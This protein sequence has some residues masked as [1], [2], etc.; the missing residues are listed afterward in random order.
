[1]PAYAIAFLAFKDAEAYQRYS[2][3]L[4]PLLQAHGGT[5]LAGDNHP[6]ALA[7]PPCDR[8]VLLQFAD[9]AAALKLFGSAEYAEIAQDRDKGAHV[10][11][12][13]VDSVV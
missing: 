3:A 7:G 10:Q 2:R 12:Q 5:L 11:L 9:R 8:V 4:T 13:L 6:A 1:M